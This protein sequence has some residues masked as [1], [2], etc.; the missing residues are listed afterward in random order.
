M[1]TVTRLG[2]AIAL[3]V[4]AAAA[5]AAQPLK[6]EWSR[7]VGGKTRFVGVEEYGRCS[8][9]I[10]NGVIEVL[11]PAGAVAWT[12]P[13]A[14]ISKFLNPQRVAI[15]HQCDA[16]AIVGDASYKQALIA[17]QSGAVTA[18]ALTA[19][20]AEIAFDRTGRMVAVGTYAGTIALYSRDGK[21]EWQRDTTAK[22]VQGITFTDDN[23]RLVFQSYGGAG[24]VSVAGH[25]ESSTREAGDADEDNRSPIPFYR[26]RVARSED[27]SRMWLRG[28]DTLDC[29][30]W[31]G[32]VLASIAASPSPQG[33]TVSRDFTQ[34]LVVTE[35]NLRPVSVE[36]YSVTAPCRP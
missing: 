4:A 1:A 32:T 36:R 24:V 5:A 31:R 6:A 10:D 20:P 25:V 28:E 33:T 35:K 14:R 29:V 7:P 2:A 23:L 30:D 26:W 21:I 12:W 22:I 19:T 8:V 13:F 34:V 17:Q 11:T 27:G 3:V 15:A 16:V 18:L 9:F